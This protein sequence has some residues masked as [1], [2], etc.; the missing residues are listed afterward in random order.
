MIYQP[1]VLV[2]VGVSGILQRTVWGAGGQHSAQ[3]K[4][5]AEQQILCMAH[6]PG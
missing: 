5:T 1:A 6:A 4:G 2:K 3:N